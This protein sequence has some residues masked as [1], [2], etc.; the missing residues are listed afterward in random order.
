LE[1]QVLAKLCR[2]TLALMQRAQMLSLQG[3]R[4]NLSHE[5]SEAE[6]WIHCWQQCRLVG[7]TYVFQFGP[8][9][10]GGIYSY[11]PRRLLDL[12]AHITGQRALKVNQTERKRTAR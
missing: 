1:E 3:N 11:K 5:L 12:R 4:L 2:S 7:E 8:L 6:K 10:A 9:E